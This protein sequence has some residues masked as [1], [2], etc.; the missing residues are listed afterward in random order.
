MKHI[1]LG[2]I[3]FGTYLPIITH[4]QTSLPVSPAGAILAQASFQA[5]SISWPALYM[6]M[7]LIIGAL[8]CYEALTLR[9][10]AGILPNTYLFKFSSIL[11]SVWVAISIA[12]IYFGHFNGLM[13]VIPVFYIL[14]SIFGWFYGIYILKKEASS[15]KNVEE[16]A[17]PVKYL[18]YSLSFSWVLMLTCIALLIQQFYVGNFV[19]NVF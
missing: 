6:T 9:K 14:Y 18:N 15:I 2:Q 16:L 7:T 4:A 17:I 8:I 13:K 19:F 11:E 5:Q 3:L 12:A 10:N 1:Y